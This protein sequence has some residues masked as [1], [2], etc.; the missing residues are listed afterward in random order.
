MYLAVL[1]TLDQAH[2][3]PVTSPA[4]SPSCP[5]AR[6]PFCTCC[7]APAAHIIPCP[8]RVSLSVPCIVRAL[9]SLAPSIGGAARHQALFWP[10]L[11]VLGPCMC[12]A[13]SSPMPD[14]STPLSSVLTHAVTQPASA[15]AYP[16]PRPHQCCLR[17]VTPRPL[18]GRS[19]IS[20]P[21][22]PVFVLPP[23]PELS[24]CPTVYWSAI[25]TL[26]S[27]RA[28]L[29]PPRRPLVARHTPSPVPPASTDP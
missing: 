25:P 22:P 4:L 15:Q 20:R 13:P 28:S 23:T 21:G 26:Q 5:A 27:G 6:H 1:P 14:E 3:T 19:V 29:V 11:R 8:C 12:P 2:G 18:D 24:Q 17:H 9:V 10:P 7:P 16:R